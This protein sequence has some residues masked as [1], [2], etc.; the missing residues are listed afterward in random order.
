MDLLLAYG[1]DP[2]LPVDQRKGQT[3][4]VLDLAVEQDWEGQLVPLLVECPR[5]D[6][7]GSSAEWLQKAYEL[8]I[9][10]G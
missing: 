10:S 9:K 5:T 3:E 6:L 4:T 8:M 2:M 1:A 7:G